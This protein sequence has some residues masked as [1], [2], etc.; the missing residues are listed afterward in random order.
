MSDPNTLS[1]HFVYPVEDDLLRHL[2]ELTDPAVKVTIGPEIPA[3]PDYHVLVAVYLDKKHLTASPNLH[4][5][6]VPLAGVTYRTRAALLDFPEIQIYNMHHSAHQAAEM[7]IT[8]ML[9]AAKSTIPADRSLRRGDWTPRY[10]PD[11]DS[12]LEG[13]QAT[14]VGYGHIGRRIA[15][16]SRALGLATTAV[17]RS[18]GSD[19]KPVSTLGSLLPKTEVLFLCLPLTDETEN[20][21]GAEQLSLL[22]SNGVLVNVG[23]AEVVNEKALYEALKNRTIKAAGLDVWYQYPSKTEPSARAHTLPSTYPFHE[24]DN[25]V[26]SPHVAG[27]HLGADYL[28]RRKMETLADMLTRMLEGKEVKTKFDLTKGF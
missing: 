11:P 16:I 1:V 17:D 28:E 4:S 20:L 8:L 7:A 24:L 23:R 14:V 21:I 3:D 9:T 22:P 13:K 5:V 6:I 2:R 26:L 12:F 25:V 10:T 27:G 18:E 19:R 15:Q